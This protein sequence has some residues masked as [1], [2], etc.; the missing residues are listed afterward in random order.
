MKRFHETKE[1]DY[2][3]LVSSYKRFLVPNFQRSYKWGN[4]QITDFFSAID[5]N[6]PGY[7]IGNIVGVLGNKKEEER[8]VIV[9]G[10]QRITTITL[11]LVALRDCA[12]RVLDEEGAKSDSENI[13]NWISDYL[14]DR[15]KRER[16]D[17][18][19]LKARKQTYNDVLSALVDGKTLDVKCDK[20]QDAYLKSYRTLRELVNN[21]VG[22]S[23]S[24]VEELVDKVLKL[25]VVAIVLNSDKEVFDAFDGLNSKGLGLSTSD[26][27][28]NYLFSHAEKLGCLDE[29]EQKWDD[30]ET[31]FEKTNPEIITKF[32]RHL[33]I[34]EYKYVSGKDLYDVLK[35]EIDNQKNVKTTIAY[36]EKI[37]KYSKYY[38]GIK[39]KDFSHYL[40]NIDPTPRK[41]L[42]NFKFL[43]NQQVYEILLALYKKSQDDRTFK[44]KYFRDISE[45]LWNFCLRTKYLVINPS[46][47]ERKFADYCK[48]V[49]DTK[50]LEVCDKSKDFFEELRRLTKDREQF[51][52]NM[53]EELGYDSDKILVEH[54]LQK[55]IEAK[56][57]NTITLKEKSVEHILP[58]EPKL[59]GYTK[60][61]IKDY[62]HN[63]GNLTLLHPEDNQKAENKKMQDKCSQI[64]DKSHFRFNKEISSEYKDIFIDDFKIAIKRR[65]KDVAEQIYK[66]TK[67]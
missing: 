39:F 12:S 32:L 45:K 62:V 3:G 48:I 44:P 41:V 27:I 14:K 37:V 61:D 51:V 60:K 13:I 6:D 65:G 42:Y 53:A 9:D 38:L 49:R 29:V 30:M 8:L 15:D 66:M 59:W 50:S 22:S 35:K 67:I 64:Y 24:R 40:D 52:D 21:K 10:Q 28:K 36:C 63:L 16:K 4:K 18:S 25:E 58:Q 54:L 55:V 19:V 20:A 34:S 33:W 1:Y 17:F 2:A 47:Y 26:Q 56:E 57:K 7:F 31:D 5:Q 46:V 43:D 11:M 23:L